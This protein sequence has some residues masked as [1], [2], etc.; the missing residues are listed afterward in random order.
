MDDARFDDMARGFDSRLTRRHAGGL[1]TGALLALGFA[2]DTDAKKKKKKKK[3]KKKNKGGSNS[4]SNLGAIC[5]STAAG[6]CQCRRDKN[7]KQVCLAN[8]FELGILRCSSQAD[9]PKGAFCDDGSSL[10]AN[11]C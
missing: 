7:N 6:E 11:G 8:P 10:C 2:V 9:C 5:G 3:S 4:C 1:A